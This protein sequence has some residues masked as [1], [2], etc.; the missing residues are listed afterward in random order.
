[1][2]DVF[3]MI[4]AANIGC[5]TSQVLDGNPRNDAHSGEDRA[6]LCSINRMDPEGSEDFPLGKLANAAEVTFNQGVYSTAW[7]PHDASY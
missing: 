3:M 4:V 6:S 5:R 2:I 7:S 1:M